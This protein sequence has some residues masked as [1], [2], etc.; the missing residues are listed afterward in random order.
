[1]D[2]HF[3]DIIVIIGLLI[4]TFS[5]A[6]RQRLKKN[7]D[8]SYILAGRKLTTPLFVA[9]LVATWYGSILGI[10]EFINQYGTLAWIC[11]GLPYYLSAFVFALF[12][13]D[14]IRLS[15]SISIPDRFSQ[16][17]GKKSGQI[18]SIIILLITLPSAYVLMLGLILKEI[19]EI[20]LLIALILGTLFSY[21]Y[22]YKAG[23]KSDVYSNLVQFVIMYT[24]FI[25][26]FI[27]LI[28]N[29]GSPLELFENLE[30][31][32]IYSINES[33]ITYVIVWFIIALQTFVDPSF[34]QRCSAAKN[35]KI[36]KKGILY[37]ILFWILFDFLTLFTG[38]YSIVYFEIDNPVNTYLIM[39]DSVFP[40]FFKGLFLTALISTIMSSLNSY[41]FL[42]GITIG[43]DIL[44][45]YESKIK[46]LK[47][48]HN[49]L[50]LIVSGILS[51]LI[52]Y[53][54]PSIVEIFFKTSSLVIPSILIPLLISYSKTLE[55]KKGRIYYF[56]ILPFIS[57]FIT[58]LLNQDS[59]SFFQPMIVGLLTSIFISFLFVNRK[60]ISV[61]Q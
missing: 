52:A 48:N 11:M 34:F 59:N 10:G 47:V 33:N 1:M 61:T 20:N 15:N 17:Y 54:I 43:F 57:S 45:N 39:A 22:I 16:V 26:F 50:G 58:M 2:L 55:I 42:S 51:I 32:Y 37:S 38:L 23:F 35:K 44:K 12:F 41:G 13:A 27:F 30:R 6:V 46:F 40:L 56:L 7:D 24:G 36:A 18:V 8:E 3:V 28:I 60:S 29:F 49:K 5:V 53:F 19:F 14:K 21:I 4:I 9:T 31:K 25:C